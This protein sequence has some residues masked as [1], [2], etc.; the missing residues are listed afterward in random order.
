MKAQF[1][2]KVTAKNIKFSE[3]E[4]QVTI[5]S[6]GLLNTFVHSTRHALAKLSKDVAPVRIDS[7][8]VDNAG[9]IV[10][11]DKRF[12]EKLREQ[13]RASAADTNHVCNNA[14]NCQKKL[15]T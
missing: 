12:V 8:S 7:I 9:R 4:P 5:K 1:K 15:S 14:Y 6:S 10:I 13:I 11:N 2:T 3:T